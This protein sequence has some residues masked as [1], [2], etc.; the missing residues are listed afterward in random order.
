MRMAIQGIGVVGGFGCGLSA[1][2]QALA[3]KKV[4]PVYL[5]VR[6]HS[7]EVKLPVLQ[8]QTD[9]LENFISKRALRRVDHFSRLALLG[10]YLALQDAEKKESKERIGIIIATGYGPSRTTFGFL[11]SMLD[12]DITLASPTLFSN[13]VHNIAATNIAIRLGI[14]GPAIT[15]C[16]FD[17]SFQ[18]ALITAR[19]WLEQKIVDAVLLGGVDEYCEMLGYCY[20][21]FCSANK[22]DDCTVIDTDCTELPL[23][24]GSA[25]FYLT[26]EWNNA[27]YGYITKCYMS[28]CNTKKKTL[29]Y[30]IDKSRD[31]IL[32]VPGEEKS[33]FELYGIMPIHFAF[34]II[35]A[36]ILLNRQ[37]VLN[38][39]D[40]EYKKSL[41]LANQGYCVELQV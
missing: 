35:I 12:T 24:E 27:K 1:L 7:G 33:F 15:I 9:L 8:A 11:D 32:N 19:T 34:D 38:E 13:S 20:H 36:L 10:A 29:F 14:T 40:N 30:S 28:A 39:H 41:M 5:P 3:G 25:F 6:T 26:P 17:T 22:Q 31:F 18:S 4:S 37:V 2:T 23:G 21:R 16:Q